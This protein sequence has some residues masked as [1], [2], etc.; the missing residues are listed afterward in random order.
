MNQ[1]NR[2]QLISH[3][4]RIEDM[5]QNLIYVKWSRESF[6]LLA[7]LAQEMEQIA[8]SHG[9]AEL[10]DVTAQLRNHLKNCVAAK[11]IPQEIERE[12]LI[13]LIN[14]L[15]HHLSSADTKRLDTT[16]PL[17]S[18]ATEIFV[19]DAGHT[20]QLVLKLKDLGF[21]VR[22]L[23]TLAEAEAAFADATPIAVIIDVD[24]P[25]EPLAGIGMSAELRA[26]NHL[27]APV[28]FI[29]ERDD[30]TAR[31]EAVRAGGRGYFN[32]LNDIP[33]LLEE[34]KSFLFH[35]S[36]KSK[37][38]VLIVDDTY[39]EA[40]EVAGM[41]ESKGIITRIV[42][43]PMQVMQDIHHFQPDLLLLDLELKD[44][45]GPE[46][47]KAISQ[48]TACE[49]LPMILL[50]SQ[51]YLT[52]NLSKLD[53][54]GASLM[55]KPIAPDYLCWAITQRLG[56][57]RVLRS[58]LNDLRDQDFVSGLYNRRYFL[59][60]LERSVA[61]LGVGNRSVAVLFIMLD[62][63]RAIRDST[64]VVVADEVLE[65][66]AGRLRKVLGRR[67]TAAR[68][69]DAIFVVLM[70]DVHKEGLLTAARALRDA[71]ETGEY[72]ANSHI[73]LLRV[74]IGISMAADGKQDFLTLVQQADMACSLA[75][76][77][78]GEHI[79]LHHDIYAN[80]DEEEFQ[81]HRLLEEIDEAFKQQR[82]RLVFQPIFSLRGNQGERYE[83][84]L[85]IG[86]RD[87]RELLPETVF[88]ITQRHP[89]G[90]ALDRWVIAQ[91]IRQLAERQQAKAPSTTLFIKVLPVT[92]QD[93]SL[94]EWLEKLLKEAEVSA[95]QL[96][97][98]VAQASAERDLRELFNFLKNVKRL[99]CGFCLDR[100]KLDAN[101]LTL[102]KN[103]NTDYVK[104]DMYFVQGLVGDETKQQLL[105]DLMQD[106]E[107]LEVPA[108]VSGV[109]DLQTLPM[110]WS[111]GINYVQ[112]FFLQP[113][114]EE[115]S[116][117]FANGAL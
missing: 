82:M 69:G 54:V 112:G 68:F 25:S 83:V 115:M 13:A 114:L 101:S 78:K 3:L 33:A 52:R 27:T 108:I 116:Y 94:Q 106:L 80:R 60:Q 89:L 44:I 42:T 99:G 74:S 66:A 105:K 84:L 75:R 17:I 65:Q 37:N 6:K 93:E 7:L 9:D 97:F 110:L 11:H 15:R 113:P 70:N 14:Q 12:R 41:L 16:K 1:D 48:H 107:A 51:S 47:A 88:G 30:I 5:W 62:N 36:A 71:L 28:L 57:A 26:L 8:R 46:L 63:L 90:V 72:E 55:S 67:Y 39:A 49:V 104:L 92:L 85:R 103:L 59:A 98:Q 19:I 109:E 96:I 102:L 2:N 53:V 64:N 87:D 18:A 58:K 95:K 56:R 50:S 38:R 20:K 77:S 35:Q 111:Y 4:Q 32:K 29:A 22:H 100:F 61:A 31:L 86:D 23:S 10:T 24:C 40:R 45:N 81:R 21:Q 117:D 76:E 43:Q 34:L 79:Y 91:S 73:L